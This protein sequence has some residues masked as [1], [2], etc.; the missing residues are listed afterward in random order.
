M[1]VNLSSIAVLIS[2]SG[3]NLQAIIDN[4]Q[5]CTIKAQICC[6]ISNNPNAYGLVRAIQAKI[7]THVVDHKGFST[8]EEFE[9]ELV[10]VLMVYNVNFVVLAG[11]M[12]VLS[13]YFVT[14]YKDKILNIHPSLLPKFP[15]LHTHQ[16]A[17]DASEKIHGCSVHLVTT[18]LDQGSLIMQATVPVKKSDNPDDLAKR[19]LVKEHLIY[20]L[21][22]KWLIQNKLSIKEGKI[23]LD[24]KFIDRPIILSPEHELELK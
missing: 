19:V 7:P 14:K 17:I 12:R 10:N 11:F 9:K 3:S 22:I 2:G 6:V 4:V 21:T 18:E 8:R 23:Y 24:N 20:P 15:G 5:R 13:H 16:R 1:Q